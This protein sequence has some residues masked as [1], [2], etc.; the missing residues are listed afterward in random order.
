MQVRTVPGPFEVMGSLVRTWSTDGDLHGKWEF[1]ESKHLEETW[2]EEIIRQMGLLQA[3][4]QGKDVTYVCVQNVSESFVKSLQIRLD[5]V[6]LYTRRY[7]PYANLSTSD[8]WYTLYE[9]EQ[10]GGLRWGDSVLLAFVGPLGAVGTLLLNYHDTP[11]QDG[12][13]GG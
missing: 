1:S 9:I 11:S 8:V 5:G 7:Y 3:N 10:S 13:V 4:V 2:V 12:G 6:V